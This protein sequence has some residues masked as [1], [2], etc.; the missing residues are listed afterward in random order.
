VLSTISTALAEGISP[1]LL[2]ANLALQVW[3]R[4]HALY[5]AA[6]ARNGDGPLRFLT[7]P[8]PHARRDE[9]LALLAGCGLILAAWRIGA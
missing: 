6:L 5:L 2:A 9:L 4:S 1:A 3:G 8:Y 7:P